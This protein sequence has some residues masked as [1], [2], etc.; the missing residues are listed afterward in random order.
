MGALVCCDGG[1]H[2]L[3]FGTH[4]AKVEQVPTLSKRSY[5]GRELK[6][7]APSIDPEHYSFFAPG[8]GVG[9]E[10]DVDFEFGPGLMGM[11][12]ADTDL[13]MEK[14]AKALVDAAAED[15][16]DYEFFSDTD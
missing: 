13:D 6:C 8:D 7:P 12:V 1:G 16:D 10:A 2:S 5:V 4:P 3:D 9:G 15:V 14:A 11:R